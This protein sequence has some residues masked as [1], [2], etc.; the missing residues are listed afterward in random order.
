MQG[1]FRAGVC[2][3]MLS[4]ACVL[5]AQTPEGG[6]DEDKPKKSA[7]AKRQAAPQYKLKEV[8]GYVYDAATKLPAGGIKVRA[9]NNSYYTA[10]TED[11]GSYTLK[12]PEFCDVLYIAAEGYNHGKAGCPQA[13]TF[14]RVYPCWPIAIC[15]DFLSALGLRCL[16][17]SF[18]AQ[19]GG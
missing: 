19:M 13:G 16:R 5:S 3:F 15:S 8:K 6:N 18:F 14:C 1:A 4:G 9:L 11:D 12:A 7:P 17:S 2:L 10:I